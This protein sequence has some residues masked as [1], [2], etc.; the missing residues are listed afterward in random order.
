[1]IVGHINNIDKEL[2]IY[3]LAIQKGLDF[4]RSTDFSKVINGKHIID[5]NKV[6]VVIS[7]YLTASADKQKAESHA[8]Y[9]DIQYVIDGNEMMGFSSVGS[10]E[11]QENLLA[12]KDIVFYKNVKCET[13]I[14]LK[15]DM[16]AIAFPWDIHRPGC[17]SQATGN[18]RKAVLKIAIQALRG[19]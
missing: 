6:Y 19:G 15:K 17:M 13:F 7:E 8:R 14:D 11:V 16:F 12:E 4:L 1:V 10:G 5:E 9:I 3:P 2:P 18:V